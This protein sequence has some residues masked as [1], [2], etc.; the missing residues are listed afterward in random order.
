VPGYLGRLIGTDPEHLH[1]VVI[2]PLGMLVGLLA[3]GVPVCGEIHDVEGGLV[4]QQVAVELLQVREGLQ[5]REVVA[6]QAVAQSQ[7]LLKGSG[8]HLNIIYSMQTE[9]LVDLYR[10]LKSTYSMP[11]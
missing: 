5:F 9:E 4:R 10:S 3:L 8:D 2:D 11:M 1:G 7:M 6:Q